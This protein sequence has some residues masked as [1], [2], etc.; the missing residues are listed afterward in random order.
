MIGKIMIES[1]EIDKHPIK[2]GTEY[3]REILEVESKD[4]LIKELTFAI[5]E[6]ILL[7]TCKD[8]E[9]YETLKNCEQAIDS[10][11]VRK[12]GLK[13]IVF[14]YDKYY[15]VLKIINEFANKGMMEI[16]LGQVVERVNSYTPARSEEA[17]KNIMAFY[18]IDLIEAPWRQSRYPPQLLKNR[19]LKPLVER[20]KTDNNKDSYQLLVVDKSNNKASSSKKDKS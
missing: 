12:L 10:N 3:M 19:G 13:A 16:S 1:K 4:G 5:R 18:A 20:L 6:R 7:V 15:L 8:E 14:Q 9:S 2:Y 17:I 11:Y